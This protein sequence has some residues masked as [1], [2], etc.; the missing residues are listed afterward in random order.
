VPGDLLWVRQFGTPE[1]DGL[2]ALALLPRGA[3]AGGGTFGSLK[4]ANQGGSDLLLTRYDREGRRLW[5]TQIGSPGEDRLE[6]L[7]A[8]PDG[9]LYGIGPWEGSPTLFH[10]SADG[11]LLDPR[12]PSLGEG[13][14]LEALAW[15]ADGALYAA[16]TVPLQ[17]SDALL[18]K[19]SPEGAVLWSRSVGVDGVGAQGMEVGR[20][21][22][23]RPGGGACLGGSTTSSLE[24]TNQGGADAFVACFDGEGNPLW[25]RQWGTPAGDVA[26]G[27]TADGTGL[28]A[29]LQV[30]LEGR[31]L[32]YEARGGSVW[33]SPL[34]TGDGVPFSPWA[35][36]EAP[37]GG[38]YV[39]G[40]AVYDLGFGRKEL[41]LVL[42][43]YDAGGNPLSSRLLGSG[44]RQEGLE[45]AAE[46]EGVYL[47]GTTEGQFPGQSSQGSQDAF[48]ARFRP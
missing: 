19:L 34:R 30:G 40:Q 1:A 45:L 18:V 46:A 41:Y 20:A 36:A 33:E 9:T 5:L 11:T 24:G 15:G 38:A 21:V 16:G 22:A 35:L 17:N 44:G 10:F 39:A 12:A 4:G 48:L 43:R 8:A 27:L 29:L 14:Y 28:Y 42:N 25:L 47:A 6:G 32:R 2:R 37:G 7:A 23:A 26:V 3:V 13:A 31:L